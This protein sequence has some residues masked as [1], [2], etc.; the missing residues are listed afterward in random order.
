MNFV[1]P[2]FFVFLALFIGPYLLLKG[3]ARMAWLLLASYVFYGWASPAFT[4]L[5]LASTLGDYLIGLGMEK[6]DAAGRRRLAVWSVVLNLGFLGYF[7]YSAFVWNDLLAPLCAWLGRPL[8]PVERDLPPVGISFYT[9]QT[10]SYSLDV[11]R[12]EIPASR[13][14]L[15]FATY[16]SMFPQLVAGP[17]VRARDLL[18]QLDNPRLPNAAAARAGLLRCT[19]GFLKK[20]CLADSLALLLVDPCYANPAAHGPGEVLLAVIAY[21]FQIYFDF[22]GYSDMAIGLGQLL[23][24]RFQENF[25]H[26]YRAR[27]FSEFWSRWHISLSSWLRDY[28]YIPLGGNRLGRARTLVNLLLTM[29]LGG[30][31]HGASLLFL[32]W[33]LLHGLFLVAQR[34]FEWRWPAA[35]RWVPEG[36]KTAVCFALVTLAWIPFRAGSCD[37]MLA[38][39]SG[40]AHLN[41]ASLEQALTRGSWPV[42]LLLCIC[43]AAH[44][45]AA[46][47]AKLARFRAWPL[48]LR[49][50]AWASIAF[51]CLHYFPED[52]KVQP[53][54]YFQF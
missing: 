20:A 9:F 53:F 23:G 3:S 15:R 13:S 34:L 50:A 30:L 21:S 2:V 17:I 47:L 54:I 11:W 1:D 22:S 31:W 41:A 6:R 27:S 33:G 51:W 44:F 7:K 48:E 45:L 38:V 8:L 46:P 43:F 40:L 32:L 4:L 37:K 16:V 52:A 5:L 39:F 49:L 24:F 19:R 35:R 26:P 25:D 28:L 42:G 36:I 18:P 29:L 12:G 14:L 10:L